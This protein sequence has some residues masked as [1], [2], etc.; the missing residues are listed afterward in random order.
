MVIHNTIPTNNTVYKVEKPN[1]FNLTDEM[2]RLWDFGITRAMFV[3]FTNK[4]NAVS[5]NP[6]TKILTDLLD[7][8]GEKL[9]PNYLKNMNRFPFRVSMFQEWPILKKKKETITSRKKWIGRDFVLLEMIARIMNATLKILEPPAETRYIG[10]LEDIRKKKVDFCFV[11]S[12][13]VMDLDGIFLMTTGDLSTLN[14]I[15][16]QPHRINQNEVFFLIYQYDVWICLIIFTFISIMS[17]RVFVIISKQNPKWN[18]QEI[19]F[20]VWGMLMNIPIKN[21]TNYNLVLRTSSIF[22]VWACLILSVSFQ[23]RLI[24]LMTYPQYERGLRTLKDLENSDLL[25]YSSHNFTNFFGNSAILK[26][27]LRV[28]NH[29]SMKDFFRI[30]NSNQAFAIPF[31]VIRG[32]LNPDLFSAT[33][34]A[35]YVILPEPLA[36]SFA[37]YMF[38]ENS[39]YLTEFLFNIMLV[40]QHGFIDKL[41]G[42]IHTVSK[43][44]QNVKNIGLKLSVHHLQPAFWVLCIGYILSVVSMICEIIM[45]SLSEPTQMRL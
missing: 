28:M 31:V 7:L 34:T 32:K 2:Q 3:Y 38:P 14:V 33:Q 24:D 19:T 8:E 39:P 21:F 27:K 35:N 20:K 16:P 36:Y 26:H 30:N 10:A 42:Q 15:V 6:F 17:S 18:L 29:T 4:L 25:L 37:V 22:W 12:F 9:F 43:K 45:N 44:F 41:V 23:C 13:R 5:F 1:M 40:K 11:R